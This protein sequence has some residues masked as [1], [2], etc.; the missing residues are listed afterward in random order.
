MVRTVALCSIIRERIET[1]RYPT[2]RKIQAESGYP[3]Y[4]VA[5]TSDTVF[6]CA[7]GYK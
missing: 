6:I 2:V 5:E 7:E 3:L 4:R 1:V